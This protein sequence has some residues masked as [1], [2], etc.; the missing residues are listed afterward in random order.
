M[1]FSSAAPSDSFDVP[2]RKQVVDLGLSPEGMNRRVSLHCLYYPSFMVKEIDDDNLKGA[3]LSILP[4]EKGGPPKCTQ[5]LAKGEWE[6]KDW[7]GYYMGA[8]ANL[9]FFWASDGENAGMPFVVY[10][11]KSGNRIFEDSTYVANEWDRKNLMVPNFPFNR[12]RLRAT[13]N[14]DITLRYM[15]ITEAD[16]DLHFASGKSSCWQNIRKKLGGIRARIPTCRGYENIKDREDSTIA[17]PVE[18]ILFPHPVIRPL[19]GPIGCWAPN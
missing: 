8:R 9:I 10:D 18:A 1:A 13:P 12:M 14:G 6:I 19:V 7:S 16:C 3:A 11:S 4:A 2:L 15:R 17:Y 5:S